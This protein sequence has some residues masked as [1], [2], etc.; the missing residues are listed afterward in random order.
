MMLRPSASCVN[1]DGL[2][3][4]QRST[5]CA[6]VSSPYL[7]HAAGTWAEPRLRMSRPPEPE[8]ELLLNFESDA[9]HDLFFC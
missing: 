7:A 5:R 8:D 2:T 3:S 9:R 4:I 6:T 1:W